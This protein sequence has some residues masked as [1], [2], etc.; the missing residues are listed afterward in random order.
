MDNEIDF[1]VISLV[2]DDYDKSVVF[3]GSFSSD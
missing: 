1:K 2:T 3:Y